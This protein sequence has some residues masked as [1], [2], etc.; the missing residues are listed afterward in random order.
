MK[1]FSWNVNGLRAVIKKGEF[2]KFI[3]EYQ[4]DILCL[5][6]TKANRGQVEIDLP[7]Y[8]EFWNSAERPGYS[9]TAIFVKKFLSD[10]RPENILYDLPGN[11]VERYHLY[12]DAFGNPNTEGRVLTLEMPEF[13]LAT[14]YTPNSKHDL[15]RLNLRAQQ[16][17]PA[18]RDYISE[19]KQRKPVVFCGDLN[20]AHREIDLARPK[21][22]EKNAGFTH[23]E[24]GGFENFLNAG[25]IDSFRTI[26]G[27]IS[28]AYTWWTW[29]AKAR[30]RNVGWRIDYFLVDE[31]LRSNLSDAK[32]YPGQ[33]GS[34][35]CPI[36]IEL[37][38]D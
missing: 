18:F 11:L 16:W 15:N 14:V 28:D 26:H 1:I 36:M 12:D 31:S 3:N 13:Y 2:Q 20:V 38:Y 32:I 19:L 5:Q 6:E 27:D 4:P 34:D 9:G 35:H 8:E 21:D 33:M 17:D 29:R 24:R 22:N 23:E 30:E 10:L 37:R 25:F 7:D